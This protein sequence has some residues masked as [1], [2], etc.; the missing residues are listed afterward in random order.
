MLFKLAEKM[1]RLLAKIFMK[2]KA[3][4][5]SPE[6]ARGFLL[7]KCPLYFMPERIVF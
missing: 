3:P 4:R 1:N 2:R 5:L 6:E 7:Q